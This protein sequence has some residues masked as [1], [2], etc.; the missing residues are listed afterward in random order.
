MPHSLDPTLLRRIT[1]LSCA[2]FASAVATRIA[3]ALLPSLAREFAITPGAAAAVVSTFAMAYGLLQLFFGPVGDRY[4]KFHVVTWATLACAL[5]AAGAAAMHDFDGLVWLRMLTGAANAAVIPLAM[6]WIADQVP[7][8][9]RQPVLARFLTGQVLGLGSG[10]LLGGVL[11]DL[12]GWRAALAASA[13]IYAIV[14]VLLVLELRRMREA[15]ADAAATQ[16]RPSSPLAGYVDV[17]SNPWAR[18]LLVW[19]YVEG[20]LQVGSMAFV[21]TYL[22]QHFGLPLA[23]SGATM[24]L[25]SLGGFTYTLLARALLARYAEHGMAAAGGVMLG[26]AFLML[27]LGPQVGWSVPA[28]LVMGLGFYMLHATM[29]THATQM[30]P[31]ARG[32]AVALFAASLFLGQ[33]SGVWLAA[34]ISDLWGLRAVFGASAL[35]LLLVGLTFAAALRARHARG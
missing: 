10:Q 3:D 15:P 33:A 11:V 16:P 21:P 28:G 5:F 12:A 1:V 6:A 29:Q 18:R 19:V 13:A 32:T 22:H 27:A 7:Y 2:G 25:F 14:F 34:R 4:P 31:N 26:S 23:L 35:G 20:A 8:E 24:V 17:L 9:R 30:A